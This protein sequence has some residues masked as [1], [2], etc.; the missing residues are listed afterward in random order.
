MYISPCPLLFLPSPL[1][2]CPLLFLPSHL[3]INP[4][5]DSPHHYW[6]IS[7]CPL[8]FLPSPLYINPFHDSLH[9]SIYLFLPSPLYVNPF[10]DSFHH[11]MYLFLPSPLY[12]NPFHDSLHHYM[13]ISYSLLRSLPVPSSSFPLLHISI[14]SVI[15]SIILCISLP[16][17][18]SSSPSSLSPCPFLFLP[19]PL[20]INPF[21]DSLHHSMYIT[22]CPSSSFPLLSISIP[23]TI[24]SIILCISLPATSSLYQS[25]L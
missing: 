13:Y 16:A 19:S 4:F 15:H 25:L 24:H 5:R 6:Y 14:P 11:S 21:H 12:V 23:S 8:F 20:Y 9:H 22:P 2:P 18:F 17:H 7:P 1:S 3:Y 10:H